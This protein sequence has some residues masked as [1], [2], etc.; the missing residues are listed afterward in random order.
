MP[1]WSSATHKVM[2][3]FPHSY[4]LDNNK[5]YKYYELLPTE[6][7][8]NLQ[9]IETRSKANIPT[10]EQLKKN[11]TIKRRFNKQSIDRNLVTEKRERK[12][13]NRFHY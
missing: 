11:I 6:T 5:R 12:A 9:V 8:K 13:T 4:I 10:R 2:E 7:V 3:V 1:K